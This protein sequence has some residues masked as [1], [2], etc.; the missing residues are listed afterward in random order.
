MTNPPACT[1]LQLPG[2]IRAVEILKADFKDRHFVT[3]DP[4]YETFIRN[5]KTALDAHQLPHR[6][7]DEIFSD[8]NRATHPSCHGCAAMMLA[9]THC[10]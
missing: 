7:F 1:S 5:V 6:V 10:N 9:R 3:Y 4:D 2:L 8:T